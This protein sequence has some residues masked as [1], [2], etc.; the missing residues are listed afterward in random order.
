[1]S[2][3]LGTTRADRRKERSRQLLAVAVDLFRRHGYHQ[4]GMTDIAAGAGLS[5]P[6]VYRYFDSKQDLLSR[7]IWSLVNA[8]EEQ[9]TLQ[10]QGES[11][12]DRIVRMA[13]VSVVERDSAALW[14]RDYHYLPPEE[15]D[16]LRRRVDKTLIFWGSELRG[17]RPDLSDAQIRLL[18]W[19]GHGALG[20]SALYR[21]RMPRERYVEL[22]SEATLR[23]LATEFPSPPLRGVPNPAEPRAGRPRWERAMAEAARLF[24]ERGYHAVSMEDIG[25]AA[26]V[27]AAALYKYTEGKSELL[28]SMFQR[29]SD[30][31]HAAVAVALDGVDDPAAA[32]AVLAETRVAMARDHGDILA[33]YV[34]ESENLP[35][36]E[37][38]MLRRRQRDYATRWVRSIM[39][40]NPGLTEPEAR[41]LALCAVHIIDDFIRAPDLHSQPDAQAEIVHCALR[42]MGV[43]DPAR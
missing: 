30:R 38:G 2:R 39:A 4:V 1:M 27:T 26:G 9:G 6:A 21:V 12:R 17:R 23:V 18:A 14:Q 10:T 8:Y 13:R 36:R 34:T 43:T 7:A 5:G 33:V 41:V 16:E 32:L 28:S 40:L 24:R 19:A 42:A 20:S 37:L 29:A 22:L 35:P 31:L 11:L 3:E 15:Q 25:A